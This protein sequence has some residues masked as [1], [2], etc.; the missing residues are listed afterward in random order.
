MSVPLLDIQVYEDVFITEQNPV[1][2][3]DEFARSLMSI[4]TQ[5]QDG[6]DGYFPDLVDAQSYTVEDPLGQTWLDGVIIVKSNWTLSRAMVFYI[7]GIPD[8]QATRLARFLLPWLRYQDR[9]LIIL[10]LFKFY[11]I[12]EKFKSTKLCI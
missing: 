4:R 12:S 11:Y 3:Q 7:R 9:H 8:N 10:N 5:P 1:I 6:F 2:I